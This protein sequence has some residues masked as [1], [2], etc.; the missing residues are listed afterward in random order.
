MNRT[1]DLPLSLVPRCAIVYL[2]A[3]SQVLQNCDLFDAISP[4]PHMQCGN[5]E[6]HVQQ[7]LQ[8][9]QNFSLMSQAASFKFTLSTFMLINYLTT[10]S[11]R[12]SRRLQ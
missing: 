7:V 2:V 11:T 3:V 6:I 1:R 9:K 4:R 5:S 10:E 8:R 12:Y